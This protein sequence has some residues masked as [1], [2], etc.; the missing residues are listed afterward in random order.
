[1]TTT[2]QT[3][4]NLPAREG[5]DSGAGVES[6]YFS[7]PS[8]Y[9]LQTSWRTLQDQA[10]TRTSV[11]DVFANRVPVLR[12][13]S[14]LSAAECARMLEI[15]ASH[16]IPAYFAS[17][18][19]AYALQN[20]WRDEAGIDVLQRVA[21][22]LQETTGMMVQ[23]ARE[24]DG[25]EYYAGILRAVDAGM[26]VH[27]DFAP[28]EAVGWS[29]SQSVAQLTWNILLNQVP[30]GD[31]LI[32]D[33]QWRAPQDDMAWR[34]EFPKDSYHPQMLEGHTFKAM[35]PAPGDLTFFNPRNFH[36]V[37]ACDTSKEHPKSAVRF[38]VSSFVGYLP[39][40]DGESE[41]LILWS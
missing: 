16:E 15:V 5:S 20:R 14:F 1:M 23:V 17:T 38:T 7:A 26:H 32:Y 39:A 24:E 19:A 31:T 8:K 29:V 21:S 2:T 12:E 10:I 36:E 13:K 30:G 27:A 6:D 25:R 18:P 35:K 41:K 37:R 34:K 22:K 33:R 4:F 3:F 40:R 11:L 28:Y 9:N